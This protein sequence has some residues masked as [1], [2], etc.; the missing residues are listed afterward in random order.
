MKGGVPLTDELAV[1]NVAVDVFAGSSA[2]FV[3]RLRRASDWRKRWVNF[4]SRLPGSYQW[5]ID[6]VNGCEKENT[7]RMPLPTGPRLM[8]QPTWERLS[9]AGHQDSYSFRVIA[10]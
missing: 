8:G 6:A 1:W 9:V 2:G 4:S 10:S 7:F 3:S 5:L